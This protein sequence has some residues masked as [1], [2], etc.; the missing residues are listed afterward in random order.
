MYSDHIDVSL[1]HKLDNLQV[2]IVSFR[3]MSRRL[4]NLA[5]SGLNMTYDASINYGLSIRP[6]H[7]Q[8]MLFVFIIYYFIRV[9]RSPRGLHPARRH[10]PPSPHSCHH[11][12]RQRFQ[13]LRRL[14]SR[15][16]LI[17]INK[18][19]IPSRFGEYDT[20]RRL[21]R[22]PIAPRRHTPVPSPAIPAAIRVPSSHTI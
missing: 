6:V 8:A 13:F 2:Y 20:G 22:R 10:K 7:T 16:L 17:N 14:A 19:L 1:K 15:V 5:Y 11:A 9:V 3:F 18:Q 12:A 21:I 4:A